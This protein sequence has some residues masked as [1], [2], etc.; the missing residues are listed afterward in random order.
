MIARLAADHPEFVKGLVLV[1]PSMDPE[2]EKRKW[3]NY[4]AKFPPVKWSISKDWGNS[5][6]E[7][8]PHKSELK[9]LAEL[10]PE[11]ET[12]TIVIQGML[13]ELVPPGNADYVERTMTNS[14]GLDI[15]RVEDLNHFVPWRRPDLIKKA[16]FEIIEKE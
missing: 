8:F 3:F 13:D 14:V 16:V 4:A 15:W 7:I 2:L 12:R 9:K 6:D 1:A 10:L 5:N 11:I